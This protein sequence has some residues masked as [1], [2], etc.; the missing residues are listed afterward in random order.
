MITWLWQTYEA[1]TKDQLY[2][3]LALREKVFILE[4]KCFYTDLDYRDQK[5][6]HLLGILDNQLACYLRILPKG[7][8]YPDIMSFGRVVTAPFARGLGLGKQMLEETLL[9]FKKHHPDESI[10]ISAQIYL[11]KFYKSYGF[12]TISE[13]YDDEGV[14]HVDMIKT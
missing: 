8:A 14:I 10:K 13:P 7:I 9:Y 6:V 11:E 3:I 1:L 5:S 12:E 2:D 4:Q